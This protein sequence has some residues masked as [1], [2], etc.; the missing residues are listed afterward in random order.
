ML[1]NYNLTIQ[2]A[3]TNHASLAI[4]DKGISY[5]LIK[6]AHA[7]AA[8]SLF[9]AHV[10]HYQANGK[11][12][13]LWMSNTTAQDG[14]KPYR[15]GVPICWPWFGPSPEDVGLGKPAHGFA[16]NMTWQIEGVSEQA[17]GTL[18]HLVLHSSAET[19]TMWPHEFCLEF[20]VFIGAELTMSLTTVNTGEHE[21]RYRGALHSYFETLNTDS[22]KVSGLG[23]HFLDKLAKN[24]GIQTGDFL[25]TEAVD[26][27][28]TAPENSISFT[29]GY[30]TMRMDNG[31]ANSVVVW[32]PWENGAA[33]M[34]DFDND[35]WQTM[36]CVET[37]LTGEGVVVAAGE[38]H[39]LS[40]TLRY[41]A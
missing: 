34:A 33:N 11:H 7:E 41:I 24:E 28:Y 12:P 17:E 39:T 37:A 14:S 23:N 9:G 36:A 22:V 20:E 26:R 30:E 38:E 21:L 6:N 13:L 1:K 32:N 4:S 3:L 18:V 35:R 8:I 16:R 10:M 5:I 31:N 15:G 2:K 27:V 19:L 29:N 25:L 40:A